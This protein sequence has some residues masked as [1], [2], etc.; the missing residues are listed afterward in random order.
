MHVHVHVCVYMR[1]VVL[2][3]HSINVGEP[4]CQAW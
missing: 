1:N 4:G 3:K 2:L